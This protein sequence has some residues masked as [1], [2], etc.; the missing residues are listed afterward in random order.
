MVLSHAG[1][2]NDLCLE[3]VLGSHHQ[4]LDCMQQAASCGPAS[5]ANGAGTSNTDKNLGGKWRSMI[6]THSM[7]NERLD[8]IEGYEGWEIRPHRGLCVIKVEYI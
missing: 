7:K 2:E 6:I 8:P 1:R 4:S 3:N 5:T